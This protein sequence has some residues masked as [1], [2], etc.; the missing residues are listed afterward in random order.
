MC[1][2]WLEPFSPAF[3]E[4]D[5]HWRRVEVDELEDENFEDKH[6]F[7]FSLSAMHL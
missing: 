1:S 5:I 4:S 6:V 7:I 2:D 3:E